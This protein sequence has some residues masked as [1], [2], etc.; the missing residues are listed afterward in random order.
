LEQIVRP[1][2]WIYLIGGALLALGGCDSNAGNNANRGPAASVPTQVWKVEA[3]DHVQL[4]EFKRT[5]PDGKPIYHGRCMFKTKENMIVL[6]GQF[7]DGKENGLWRAWRRDGKKLFEGDY[8]FGAKNGEWIYWDENGNVSKRE[9]W[10]NGRMAVPIDE[11]IGASGEPTTQPSAT[12]APAT[13]SSPASQPTL[14][15][16]TF[17]R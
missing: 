11:P 10:V 3:P 9:Q 5:G 14:E 4:Y 15:M 1:N 12:T 6:D 7:L 17:G 2:S 13:T 16:P 8:V